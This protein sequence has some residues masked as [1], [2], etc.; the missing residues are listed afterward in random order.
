MVPGKCNGGIFSPPLVEHIL[1]QMEVGG[2][3]GR[4]IAETSLLHAARNFYSA[5]GIPYCLF[6]AIILASSKFK[7]ISQPWLTNAFNW[8]D[9]V[10]LQTFYWEPNFQLF[11][12]LINKHT[13]VTNVVNRNN[14]VP[15]PPPPFLKK[16]PPDP[17]F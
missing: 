4:I 8:E 14:K 17:P 10:P 13:E 9:M 16:I 1:L 2:G 12:K 15:P 6:L 7:L 11:P 5:L 3:G